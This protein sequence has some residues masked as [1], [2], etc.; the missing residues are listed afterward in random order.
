MA[1]LFSEVCPRGGPGSAVPNSLC[2]PENAIA[3]DCMRNFPTQL[4]HIVQIRMTGIV[5]YIESAK[6]MLT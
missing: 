3:W 2:F 1:F 5:K 6:N 4:R